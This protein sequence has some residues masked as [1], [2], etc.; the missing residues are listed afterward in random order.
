MN[1]DQSTRPRCD[2]RF[3]YRLTWGLASA[4]LLVSAPVM[5][6]DFS[7]SG[8]ADTILRMRRDFDKKDLYPLYEYLRVSMTNS[9]T[10]GGSV[11][12]HAGMWGRVDLVDRSTSKRA[13]L[14][15]QYGYLSYRG[16]KSNTVVNAGRHFISEG[17]AAERVDGLYVRNDF[18]GGITTAAFVGKPVLSGVK[19]SESRSIYGGRISHSLPKYY[20]VGLSA[21][22]SD[23][24]AG[25]YREEE[26]LD[27]WLHPLQGLD[28]TGRSSYNSLTSGWMEHDYVLSYSP[29][30]SLV[31]SANVSNI[32]YR[33]YFHN[34]SVSAFQMMGGLLPADEELT[35]LGGSATYEPIKNLRVG[36]DYKNYSYVKTG[37]ADYYGGNASYA[38]PGNYTTGLSVHRM[39]G[40]T[41]RLRYTE[42]RGFISKQIGRAEVV[43]DAIDVHYDRSLNGVRDSYAITGAATYDL[44][45]RLKFGANIEY[46][47]N[48]DFDNEVRGLVRVTYMFDTKRSEGRGKSEK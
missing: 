26:G 32:N 48:P 1:S 39:D 46:S 35:T 27:L 7:V 21:V 25:Q 44:N 9:L 15:L 18:A 12:L 14:D 34:M 19:D 6:G 41:D 33:D 13:D 42:Y 30:Q 4:L 8:E 16:A 5:A 43:L 28:I 29:L 20:T 23:G 45:A 38:I 36:V 10:D 47:K 17:V 22:K 24:G 40:T 31:L 3:P 11:S 2:S 37:D